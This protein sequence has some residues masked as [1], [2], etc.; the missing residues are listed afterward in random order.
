[1]KTKA[2]FTLIILIAL[3]N[4]IKCQNNL[5]DFLIIEK[6]YFGKADLEKSMRNSENVFFNNTTTPVIAQVEI[7]LKGKMINNLHLLVQTEN[8][9]MI[10]ENTV[11]SNANVAN[12]SNYISVW[13]NSVKGKIIIHSNH[14]FSGEDGILLKQKL[15]EISGLPFE[16]R[17]IRNN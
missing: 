6:N 10:F 1:M 17:S 5:S 3:C 13:K 12:F 4:S 14:I 7:I 2:F 15:E 9:K 8:G 16:I 11:L